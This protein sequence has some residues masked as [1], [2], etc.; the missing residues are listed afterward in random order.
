MVLRTG[1]PLIPRRS[2]AAAG[3]AAVMRAVARILEREAFEPVPQAGAL[4]RAPSSAFAPLG[5]GPRRSPSPF[6]EF[7]ALRNGPLIL[8]AFR[9]DLGQRHHTY[10]TRACYVTAARAFLRQHGDRDLDEL[11]PREVRRYLE[12]LKAR[13]VSSSS[14]EGARAG[15]VQFLGFLVRRR[16]QEPRE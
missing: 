5:R 14:R 12:A 8:N 1:S 11:T 6:V 2:D 16:V 13:G 15:L 10:A 9:S 4:E 7:S 3:L